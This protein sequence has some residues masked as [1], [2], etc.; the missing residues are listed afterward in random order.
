[1]SPG[2]VG[3]RPSSSESLGLPSLFCLIFASS[4][5][6]H[7]FVPP[8]PG[9]QYLWG[10]PAQLLSLELTAAQRETHTHSV[11]W[12]L[13]PDAAGPGSVQP[14]CVSGEYIELARLWQRG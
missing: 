5:S 2:Q 10:R 4:N 7:P 8:V 12:D 1:M 14:T 9:V 11:A 3:C 13:V 6:G